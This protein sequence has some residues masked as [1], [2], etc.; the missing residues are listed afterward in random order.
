MEVQDHR[1]AQLL[2]LFLS[3]DPPADPMA[4]AADP[5]NE[6]EGGE[7]SVAVLP[8]YSVADVQRVLCPEVRESMWAWASMRGEVRRWR[9]DV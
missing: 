1:N 8:L 3:H 5:A 6:N 9:K 4:F 7:A 2:E